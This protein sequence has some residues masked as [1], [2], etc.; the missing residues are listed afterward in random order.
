MRTGYIIF[1]MMLFLSFSEARVVTLYVNAHNDENLTRN[2]WQPTVDLLNQKITDHHFELLP[3]KP[4]QIRLIKEL[5]D[6]KKIDFLIT[7]PAIYVEL[8]H[9]NHLIRMLTMVNK[10]N[11]TKFGSV[12]IT[13][14]ESDI[15]TIDDIRD[16]KIAAVAPMGFG[17]W[18]IG[19]NELY[20][21][22]IDP[23]KKKLVTFTG[24]Q[25][26]VIKGVQEGLYDVGIIR[27]GM[28]E[29][30]TGKGKID[31]NDFFIVNEKKNCSP[32]R[33]S[34]RL[35]P[36]WILSTAAHVDT[37]LVRDVFKVMN[38]IEA[39]STAARMGG[40]INWHLAEN[41]TVVDELFRKFHIGH[42]RN[43]PRYTGT[44]ITFLVVFF[45]S[46]TLLTGF[47]F[48]Y[49][50]TLRINEELE[51]DV[52]EKVA[53]L[54]HINEELNHIFDIA[55]NI[56]IITLGNEI[57]KANRA[58]LKFTGYDTMEA[59]KE[60][61]DCI[62]DLFVE[63]QG[64]LQ[65]VMN[66]VYW[67]EYI[68]RNP[69]TDHYAIIRRNGQENIF[70]V[71]V[72]AYREEH[73]LHYVVLFDNITQLS[74]AA[75]SDHLTSLANRLKLNEKLE[76][77]VMEYERYKRPFSFIIVD[78]DHFKNVNDT[79]GHLAGDMVLKQI[80]GLLRGH[81]RKNDTVGRWG[82]EEF[83]IICSETQLGGAGTLA[84]HLR[85]RITSTTFGEVGKVTASFGVAE[86]YEG[87]SVNDLILNAD[88]ALYY[89][90]E[91]GRNRIAVFEHPC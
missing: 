13:K 74:K 34:T 32:V 61:H 57:V 48:H 7:Q 76:E 67:V 46:L 56:I 79:Y 22:G 75:M 84:E 30:L 36:E 88:K 54:E 55:P 10:Y 62:C 19:Y 3:I 64:Y 60:D 51:T 78:I 69:H 73:G 23:L 63:A 8:E 91:N 24:S 83:V 27:T 85:V 44:E 20:N 89:A 58:F 18:L 82:G 2:Q 31:M 70:N 37:R 40:Y 47:L 45:A 49:R 38:S 15:R 52:R 35:Y 5:L 42:Y 39:N 77:H 33:I 72:E 16:K 14:K 28:L 25:E 66:G 17:G 71:N 68:Y 4:T 90:K 87:I 80:A 26:G 86:Y 59:F 65:P 50:Y 29:M 9:S 6:Q 43:T 21:H 12:F 41:Y 11:M 81:C 53:E 1:L